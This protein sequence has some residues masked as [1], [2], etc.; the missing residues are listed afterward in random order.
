MAEGA[1]VH[2][3]MGHDGV[4]SYIAHVA[5]EAFFHGDRVFM[6]IAVIQARRG[7]PKGVQDPAHDDDAQH[8]HASVKVD[9][10]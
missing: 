1:V 5:L 3:A 4:F 7:I 9:L 10:T 2:G 8:G 6:V